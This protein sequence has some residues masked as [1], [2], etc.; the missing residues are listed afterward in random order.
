[1]Q[2]TS[3]DISPDRRYNL[4]CIP[5]GA[6]LLI[7]FPG[8]FYPMFFPVGLYRLLGVPEFKSVNYGMFMVGGWLVYVGLTV[9]QCGYMTH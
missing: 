6:T 5:W 8:V 1:M 7:T 2:E 9:P 4:L 3:A